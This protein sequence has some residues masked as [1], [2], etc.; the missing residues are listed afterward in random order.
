MTSLPLDP[1]LNLGLLENGLTFYVKENQKPLNALEIRLVVR[2]GSLVEEEHE[3]GLAHFLEHLAFKGTRSFDRGDLIKRLEACGVQYGQHLNASTSQDHTIFKLSVP[4]GEG[5]PLERLN[6]ALSV[7]REFS[8]G[9]RVSDED[10]ETERGVIEEERRLKAGPGRRILELWWAKVFRD[11]GAR[12][13]AERFPI[14]LSKVVLNCTPETIRGFYAKWY[15]PDL[16]G[17]MVVGDLAKLGGAESVVDAVRSAFS[18]N[19]SSS[20]SC[21]TSSSPSSFLAENLENKLENKLENER[22]GRLLLPHCPLPSHRDGDVFVWAADPELAHVSVTL[23]FFE[24]LRIEPTAQE[25][26]RDVARRLL[27]TLMDQRVMTLARSGEPPSVVADKAAGDETAVTG[28]VAWPRPFLSAGVSCRPIIEL[29]RCT[30]VSCR[31]GVLESDLWAGIAGLLTACKRVAAHG[32]TANEFR[33]AQTKWRRAF[34]SQLADK[35]NL[36]SS[37]IVDECVTHFLHEG[38]TPLAG[39]AAELNLC[40]QFLDELQLG[41]VNKFAASTFDVSSMRFKGQIGQ[42]VHEAADDNVF[43][44]LCIQRPVRA[45]V[46]VIDEETAV[47]KSKAILETVHAAAAEPWPTTEPVSSLVT[48]LPQARAEQP[49]LAAVKTAP[50][51]ACGASEH[52]LSNGVR[53]CTKRCP[54]F[55]QGQVSF[56]AFALGGSSEL[57]EAE[58]TAFCLIDDVAEKSGLGDL[59]GEAYAHLQ[60]QWQARVNTQRHTYHRG[61]GGSAPTEKLRELL[62]MLE[63]KLTPGRQPFSPGALAQCVEL[64]VEG[65]RFRDEQ[66]EFELMERARVMAFSDVPVMRPTRPDLLRAVTVDDL[67]RLYAAAFTRRPEHFT[68]VFVGDL[69]ED[70]TLL[71]LLEEHLG[72]LGRRGED[73]QQESTYGGGD[74]G[75]LFSGLGNKGDPVAAAPHGPEVAAGLGPGAWAAA[76]CSCRACGP[77]SAGSGADGE[78]GSKA[79]ERPSCAARAKGDA[80]T[81]ATARSALEP[82]GPWAARKT[83]FDPPGALLT[84]FTAGR[85]ELRRGET[86]EGKASTLLIFRVP[87]PSTRASGEEEDPRSWDALRHQLRGACLWLEARLLR[88][89]RTEKSLVYNV[90]AALTWRSLAPQALVNV[91][92]SCEPAAAAEALEVVLREIDAAAPT[93]DE[94]GSVRAILAEKHA[95]EALTSNSHWLFWLLDAYKAWGSLQ[96]TLQSN[97]RGAPQGSGT[98]DSATWVDTTA[99]YNSVELV[100]GLNQDLD[101]NSIGRVIK[102]SLPVKECIAL[103]LLPLAAE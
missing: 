94:A 28:S 50:L 68:F 78:A 40:L 54:E 89:L 61:L 25:I 86:P 18:S 95:A 101:S 103:S 93:E 64:Q 38:T 85:A 80:L 69:P 43:K 90:S 4:L 6:L 57:T 70:A 58:E 17:V 2:I 66:P 34:E 41:D 21:P 53:V 75:G 12:L 33:L 87:C 27:T 81:N 30:G 9:I 74:T 73:E 29:L 72:R 1:S 99:A 65:L 35:A 37:S 45:G 100:A 83:A 96:G 51:P 42:Q 16:T 23:E 77:I 20:S 49:G 36:S 82:A 46:D 44:V 60:A 47:A 55:R 91:T 62:A 14:G 32:F 97:H 98:L 48:F 71:P 15:R 84:V 26:R 13:H 11:G 59:D 5:D 67:A 52:T 39:H 31:V 22:P 3:R 7:I 8:D 56:Q 102:N 92:W 63:L 24:P 76:G 79:G 19:S 10:V 88:V